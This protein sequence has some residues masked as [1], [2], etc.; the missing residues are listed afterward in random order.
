VTGH[1]LTEEERIL[2]SKTRTGFVFLR[3]LYESVPRY[4]RNRGG[5]VDFFRGI[6][7]VVVEKTGHVRQI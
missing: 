3:L 2:L 7:F 1:K 5:S 4:L 6:L